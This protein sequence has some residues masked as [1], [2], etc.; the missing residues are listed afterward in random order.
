MGILSNINMTIK[1]LNRDF[2]QGKISASLAA[3]IVQG[4]ISDLEC[5]ES[6]DR[7]AVANIKRALNLYKQLF[8]AYIE[9]QQGNR[10][11]ESKIRKI[12]SQAS[13]YLQRA[14]RYVSKGRE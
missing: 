11:T 8:E 13:A 4:L 12:L 10:I 9:I 7:R 14:E 5:A 2:A 6:L 3:A 1:R